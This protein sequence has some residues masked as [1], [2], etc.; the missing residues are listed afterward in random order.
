MNSKFLCNGIFLKSKL[1]LAMNKTNLVIFNTNINI[2]NFVIILAHK[3]LAW[4][5]GHA[6][7]LRAE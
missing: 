3:E 1:N 4:S 5:V 6:M 2:I 7:S